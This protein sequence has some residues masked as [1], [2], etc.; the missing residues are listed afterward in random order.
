MCSLLWDGGFC[1]ISHGTVIFVWFSST[2]SPSRTAAS[3]EQHT[4]GAGWP[5]PH[6]TGAQ[7]PQ[8]GCGAEPPG[9]P[10]ALCSAEPCQAAGG[11]LQQE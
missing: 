2:L 10:C 5:C 4:A 3:A 11:E 6:V 7:P 8:A 9:A 1:V